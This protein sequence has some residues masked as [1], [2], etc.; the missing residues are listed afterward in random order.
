MSKNKEYLI[1]LIFKKL[2]SNSRKIN[3]QKK[4]F[5][6]FINFLISNN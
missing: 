2:N 5:T 3:L 4:E 6:K 1:E